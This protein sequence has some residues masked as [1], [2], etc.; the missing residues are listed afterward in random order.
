MGEIGAVLGIGGIIGLMV[1]F[2]NRGGVPTIQTQETGAGA[3]VTGTGRKI[4]DVLGDLLSPASLQP[5]S[6]V[7]INNFPKDRALTTQEVYA[8]ARFVSDNYFNGEIYPVLLT[9]MAYVESSYKP[10]AIR[11]ES[12][13]RQ[14]I[15]LLQTLLGTASDMYRRGYDHMGAPTATNLKDPVV[16]MYFGAAYVDWLFNAYPGNFK[17]GTN[18]YYEWFIRAYNGG[19]GWEQSE[20]G[21]SMT[22]NHYAKVKA[23]M[24]KVKVEISLTIGE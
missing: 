15:G 11:N 8:V 2:L 5:Q 12:G 14:S 24:E 4:D 1:W 13:G 22:K 21:R 7:N 18:D 19:P 6:G 16:S 17:T 9:A 20:R 3:T 10:W 23:A